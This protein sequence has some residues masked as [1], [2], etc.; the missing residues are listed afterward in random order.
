MVR[1]VAPAGVVGYLGLEGFDLGYILLRVP[2]GHVCVPPH[3]RLVRPHV[4]PQALNLLFLPHRHLGVSLGDL[5]QVALNHLLVLLGLLPQRL[6]LCAQP[7]K[8]C[9][10]RLEYVRCIVQPKRTDGAALAQFLELR[11]ELFLGGGVA[12]LVIG[13]RCG[14]ER[15]H[16]GL[17][18]LFR[19]CAG[20]K[21]LPQVHHFED[22]FVALP[23]EADVARLV[24]F[25]LLARSLKVCAHPLD[26][27]RRFLVRKGVAI[28]VAAAAGIVPDLL[29]SLAH[30][31]G[32]LCARLRH[33][34]HLLL[35]LGLHLLEL[36]L[37]HVLH[38]MHALRGTRFP[39]RLQFE[40]VP[41]LHSRQVLLAR[42]LDVRQ[43]L[44]VL[45]FHLL[46]L[47]LNDDL[48]LVIEALLQELK[49]LCL[50]FLQL[51]RLVLLGEEHG[52]E[53]LRDEGALFHRPAC[54]L[55]R[56]S[57]LA[58]LL[59]A[60]GVLP[61]GRKGGGE[62]HQA[63][64]GALVQERFLYT[65]LMQ[66][67]VAVVR[68]G[69]GDG[70][71]AVVRPLT[72]NQEAKRI[73]PLCRGVCKLLSVVLRAIVKVFRADG[74]DATLLVHLSPRGEVVTDVA[75]VV[76]RGRRLQN[77]RGQ[78]LRGLRRRL[79]LLHSVLGK[80]GMALCVRRRALR[81][82]C[83]DC[84]GGLDSVDGGRKDVLQ[85]LVHLV[86]VGVPISHMGQHS[87]F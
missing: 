37:H 16:L 73:L 75:R 51:A 33:S 46:Q 38:V 48:H 82:G 39:R 41:C 58:P 11:P 77:R 34:R 45:G 26:D 84:G 63:L 65:G 74:A 70:I 8:V 27:L 40:L 25:P 18:L 22:R 67:E 83:S 54:G 7:L 12:R 3:P 30:G 81:V 1:L 17:K 13:R 66:L 80:G 50:R 29:R 53:A 24:I 86:A 62:P 20:V 10:H 69:G 5:L 6:V 9:A 43:D 79:Y 14:L 15:L 49:L 28:R 87:I 47:V 78:L 76:A 85:R 55:S 32:G 57:H 36:L 2:L 72:H 19:L 35:V 4:F 71:A 21:L 56:R 64:C 61:P 31:I 68:G 42:P 59:V 23:D 52:G 44:C 60:P